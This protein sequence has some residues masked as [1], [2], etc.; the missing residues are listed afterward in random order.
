MRL[1]NWV[2]DI[3]KWVSRRTYRKI[4]ALGRAQTPGN[5]RKKTPRN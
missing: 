4:V 5:C 3:C 2:L 1:R